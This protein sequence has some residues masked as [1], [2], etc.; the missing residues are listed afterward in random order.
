MISLT[1]VRGDAVK[2][3]Q[4]K[5]VDFLMHCCNAKG[6]MG[7]GIAK[8]I[9]E[10]FPSTYQAYDAYCAAG[11]YGEVLLGNIIIEDRVINAIAQF[12][13]GTSRR[14]VHYG[15][16]ASCIAQVG[17]SPELYHAGSTMR[18]IKVA[19]PYLMCCG[20]AG[21]DWTVVVEILQSLPN[22]I[23]VIIYKL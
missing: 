2:A 15:A 8:Q 13:L 9:K 17:K 14:Q 11:R 19:V 10:A 12:K 3:L 20:L 18:K 6:V 22:H 7:G 1:H 5:E 23:D 16:L 4:N 21:G